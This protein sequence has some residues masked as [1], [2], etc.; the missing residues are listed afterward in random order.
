M[1]AEVLKKFIDAVERTIGRLNSKRLIVYL[2]FMYWIYA[3]SSTLG[4]VLVA[5]LG[6]GATVILLGMFYEDWRKNP[7]SDNLAAEPRKHKASTDETTSPP[8][9]S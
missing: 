9:Q 7:K 3:L 6:G 5:A 8:A 2:I 4:Q 1:D